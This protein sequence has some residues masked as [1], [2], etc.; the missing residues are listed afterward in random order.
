MSIKF[1]SF[2]HFVG[3]LWVLTYLSILSGKSLASLDVEKIV[4]KGLPKYQ[5][6]VLPNPNPGKI[7]KNEEVCVTKYAYPICKPGYSHQTFRREPKEISC[8]SN[9]T[10]NSLSD[11]ID[12]KIENGELLRDLPGSRYKICLRVPYGCVK[13]KK[14]YDIKVI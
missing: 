13:G 4:I 14:Y 3:V 5:K 8:M 6:I 9:E 10:L 1:C 12:K 7:E 11:S 2:Y